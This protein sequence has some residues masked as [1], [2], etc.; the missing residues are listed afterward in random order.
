MYLIRQK[1]FLVWLP[2]MGKLLMR[3]SPSL[4]HHLFKTLELR[5]TLNIMFFY[6]ICTDY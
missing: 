4:Q 6:I 5:S 2:G 1:G 3:F